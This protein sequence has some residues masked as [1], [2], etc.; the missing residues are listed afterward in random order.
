MTGTK[1]ADQ[2]FSLKQW[3][4]GGTQS[5]GLRKPGC[6]HC[7]LRF[8]FAKGIQHCCTTLRRSRIKRKSD[9]FQ[10]LCNNSQHSTGCANAGNTGL[11]SQMSSNFA[12]KI[13]KLEFS[14]FCYKAQP[15]VSRK[16]DA[17]AKSLS[18]NYSVY[19]TQV[20]SAFRAFQLASSEVNSTRYSPPLSKRRKTK[21]LPVSLRVPR[22][23]L[24]R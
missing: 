8:F 2:R 7:Y 16:R 15:D 6:G 9:R 17:K 10:I 20:N 18:Q 5:R 22:S 24:Y 23:K 14:C 4:A 13:D 12:Q 21:W 11:L 1:V 19:T 3:F